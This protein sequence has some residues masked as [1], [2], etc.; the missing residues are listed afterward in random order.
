[1]GSMKFSM[2]R[3][4]DDLSFD[5]LHLD[6][7]PGSGT[8]EFDWAPLREI[9]KANAELS[10]DTEAEVTDLIGAWYQYLRLNGYRHDVAEQYLSS[11]EAEE[12]FGVDRLSS[13]PDTFH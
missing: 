13:G 7:D 6:L 10:L 5:D 1:M 3:I 4:P 9:M 2:V 12:Q 11:C 8:M